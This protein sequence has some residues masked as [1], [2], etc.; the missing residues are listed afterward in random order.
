MALRLRRR[1][2]LRRD[3]GAPDRLRPA[4]G[5]DCQGQRSR[6]RGL[7]SRAPD[8]VG[9]GVMLLQLAGALSS[10][11]AQFGVFALGAC[12]TAWALPRLLPRGTFTSR[13]G[14]PSAI[15]ARLSAMAS[16]VGLAVMIP[17]ILQRVH[18]W[19][20]ASSAWWV[21]LGFDHM[22]DRCSRPGAR[23]RSASATSAPGHRRRTH[24]DRRD[25]RRSASCS[26][27]FPC[28]WPSSAGSWSASASASSTLPCP[29]WHSRSRPKPSTGASPRG[30]RSPTRQD[31]A[32][33]LALVSVAM[34]AWAATAAVGGA[35]Y[36]PY[37]VIAGCARHP[38][39]GRRDAAASRSGIAPR[40]RQ[41]ALSRRNDACRSG[42]VRRRGLRRG[43]NRR[44]GHPRVR[45]GHA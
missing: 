25:P 36:A 22:G 42:G 41:L 14:M 40:M 1:S 18:G 24:G 38:H 15:L 17:L 3:R 27:R 37:W 39:R 9:I 8:S 13:R 29:S 30:C 31:P 20:E 21:T 4:L 6:A 5:P 26:P 7:V 28:G 16:Q 2:A 11:A 35:A 43:P 23:P 34:S 44:R 10:P 19:S 33:E 12:I 32:L 45:G